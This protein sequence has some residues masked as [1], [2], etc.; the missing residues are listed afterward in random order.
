MKFGFLSEAETAPGT[1]HY[2]RYMEV[3]DEVI[4]AEEYGWDFFGTS[5]QHF[6]SPVACVSA[7]ETF[8][9]YLAA[10]TSRIKLRHM[11]VLLPFPFN[12]PIRVAERLAT[13]DIVSNGRAELGTGRANTLLAL[14]GFNCPLDETRAMWEEGLEVVM[15][16]FISDPFSHEGQ[17]FSIPP[18][19]LSPKGVQ[20]PHPPVWMVAQSEDSH[21]VGASKGIGVLSWDLYFGWDY[22][23]K[24]YELYRERIK[25][26][27]PV[28]AFVNNCFTA[29]VLNSVC[30]EDTKG[31]MAVARQS[32]PRFVTPVIEDLYPQLGQR[33]SGGY[34]YTLKMEKIRSKARD[35]EWM[36]NETSCIAG[37]PDVFLKRCLAY[38]ELGA[39]EV[40]FRL[41]GNHEEVMRSL[42]LIGKYV[43]P[44]FATPQSVV[45]VGDLASP[46]P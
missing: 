36:V 42:K 12:H 17:Y 31:A 35:I 15:K 23:V 38:Q 30:A 8:Y 34:G 4:L 10:K 18:R 43:I 39:D 45:R 7:P 32:F 33:S 6:I 46:V 28:G 41:D 29:V 16:A 19:S 20:Q 1:T 5:E 22:V 3:V 27:K 26:A 37:D 40:V 13:L 21:E 14:D 11:V 9:P 25:T 24:N 2:R 44:H